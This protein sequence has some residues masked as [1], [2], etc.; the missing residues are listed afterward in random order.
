[1]HDMTRRDAL[2]GLFA[3]AFGTAGA[4]RAGP[5]SGARGFGPR[6][7]IRR[8]V[9]VRDAQGQRRGAGARALA[10]SDI[11][12]F[13]HPRGDRLHGVP[14]DRLSPRPR[15]VADRRFRRAGAALPCRQVFQ[16][17]V[18]H[19]A[20]RERPGARDPLSPI[21]FRDVRRPCRAPAAAGC[22]LRRLP[23]HGRRPDLGLARL[24]RRLLFPHARRRQ[25]VRHVGA[26]AG[27]RHR[28]ADARGIPALLRLLARSG[29]RP[30]RPHHHLCHARR[31]ERDRRVPL[32]LRPHATA[33]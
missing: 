21:L 14:P 24:P 19:L 9:L 18:L 1:M 26:R 16:G 31:P 8:A 32:R 13:R 15:L 25:A 33:W 12:L 23:R 11:A 4:R 30:A 29:A 10:R 27:D 28:H 3:I 17:A 2:A 6:L 20:G 22:R 5:G 7:R